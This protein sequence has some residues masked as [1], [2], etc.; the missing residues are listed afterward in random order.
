MNV[1]QS[2]NLFVDTSTTAIGESRNILIP[3]PQGMMMCEA[4][5]RLRV[6]LASFIMRKNFYSISQ[7]NSIF[8]FFAKGAASVITSGRCVIAN[9]NWQFFDAA[10]AHHSQIALAT[11]INK[12]LVAGMKGAG[13]AAPAPLTDWNPLTGR[14]YGDVPRDAS[15]TEIK[16]VAFT[17]NDYKNISGNII[18]DAIGTN[19][20]D[21]YQSSNVILGGCAHTNMDVTGTP[22]EQFDQL[23][24]VWDVENGAGVL[25]VFSS[26]FMGSLSDDNAIYLRTTL[27]NSGYETAG[28]QTGGTGFPIVTGTSILAKILINN[29][30]LGST[31]S[32]PDDEQAVDK[33]GGIS[34]FHI[35]DT[36]IITFEDKGDLLYSLI[37]NDRNVSEFS[38]RLTDRL[39]RLLPAVSNEQI[40]CN[41]LSFTACLRIDTLE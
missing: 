11:G 37:L 33:T 30:D 3:C 9:G 22:A 16:I 36:Q 25:S 29:A 24:T 40:E 1:I 2:K 13:L 10:G 15:W 23:R 5:Q 32:E 18:S 17:I 28:F 8:Y 38:L 31:H 35:P 6:T 12:A 19:R 41:N 26:Q 14:W 7:H 27:N 21:A 34:S 20:F 39:G 4:H